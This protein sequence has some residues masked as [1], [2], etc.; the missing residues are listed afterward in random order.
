[1]DRRR[2]PCNGRCSIRRASSKTSGSSV[3]EL[4]HP[5]ATCGGLILVGRNTSNF[6]A[7][8][9]LFL[10]HPNVT[11]W[12]FEVVY[13][14]VVHTSTSAL[15]FVINQPPRNGSCSISPRNGTAVVT[16]FSVSCPDWFDEDGIAAYSISSTRRV[17]STSIRSFVSGYTTDVSKTIMVAFSTVSDFQIRL[18]SENSNE[19]S[20]QLV[21]SIRDARD[22]VTVFPLSLVTIVVDAAPVNA[23][24]NTLLN[25]PQALTSDH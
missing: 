16:P 22:C 17:H 4:S 1:M 2:R 14:F 20:V 15:N 10:N 13:S 25:S 12:R 8:N 21:V 18:S 9:E 7:V 11:F 3:N 23:L 6:T 5:F 19:T 24:M